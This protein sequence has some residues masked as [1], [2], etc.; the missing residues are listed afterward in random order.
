MRFESITL[1]YT[2][3]I[4]GCFFIES[5]YVT[6]WPPATAFARRDHSSTGPHVS[7]TP[8]HL[9]V[10]KYQSECHSTGVCRT[11]CQAVTL[12]STELNLTWSS[13]VWL[14]LAW[15][16][17]GAFRCGLG[18]INTRDKRV[19]RVFWTSERKIKWWSYGAHDSAVLL[20]APSGSA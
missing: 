7:H 18:E 5:V 1:L 2:G 6:L 20:R 10:I 3:L 12:N 19:V 8:H 11:D 17:I 13:L 9:P 14:E 16:A 15:R 4:F